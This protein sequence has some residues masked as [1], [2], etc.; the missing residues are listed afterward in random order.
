[1]SAMA[2][3]ALSRV[4]VA[5]RILR[6]PPDRQGAAIAAFAQLVGTDRA[7]ARAQARRDHRERRRYAGDPW[8][9]F[10]DI[11]GLTLTQ[12]QE[13][14]LEVIERETRIL[15]PSANNQGKT[16]LGAGYGIYLF[17]AVAALP[18]EAA[19]LEEQ[20]CRLLL[21]GPD[22]NT[23]F[24]T[25]YS[26]IL[27][28]ANRAEVRGH[29]MPGERSDRSV[30]WRVR[31]KWN[32]EALSPPRRVSQ[33][34]A[35]TAS[36]RHHSNQHAIIEE[37]QG[38]PEPVWRAAEG[39][40]SSA[41]NKILSPFNPT[42]PLGP[43]FQRARSGSWRVYHLDAFR[44][45][46]VQQRQPVIPDAIDFK[47]VDAR[48]RDD[49][50]DRGAWPD[51][52]PELEQGDFVYALPPVGGAHGPAGAAA[53]GARADGI[54]GHPAGAPHVYRPNA[55]FTAQVRGQWPESSESGLFGA[56]DIDQAM[57]RWKASPDPDVATVPPDR[58]GVDP[59]REG[60]D[61][62]TAAPAWGDSAEVLLRAYAEAQKAGEEA[63]AE[64]RATRRVRIG[65]I[66]VLPKGDGVDTARRL[67]AMFPGSPFVLDD[68]GV[69]T[70]PH[71]QLYRVLERDSTP[72][73]FAASPLPRVPD[74]PWSDIL[75]TQL[76]V[77]AAMLT[78]RGMVDIPNDPLLREEL[79][80]HEV[81]ETARTAEEF[82]P[83]KKRLE[84]IRRSAV[85]LIPKDEIKKRIGRSPDRADVFVISLFQE[86]LVRGRDIRGKLYPTVRR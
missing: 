2:N 58:V 6:L 71:D 16:F 62:C 7:G 77:R 36:G 17:D 32:I 25:I 28:L 12:Q 82:N 24:E 74:E 8:A 35:H 61:D 68:G 30:L 40:C 15:L 51:V 38:V 43:A 13:E 64:L 65:R 26:E 45:P 70:S 86:P 83:Q 1:V 41:G 56:G 59:A 46:N 67:D 63:I 55:A 11:L 5:R 42:E 69:G 31:A 14:A 66:R 39:M 54:P 44:H 60:I 4:D 48:V 76:Y 72:V 29:L 57:A 84:K 73:S 33:N 34:V 81:I 37:G 80:A 22:H 79:L 49:C 21:P 85:S 50:R 75:R 10:G 47:V 19:G 3:A 23:V 78:R 18:D 52:T 9:Y 20:G 27:T 53:A